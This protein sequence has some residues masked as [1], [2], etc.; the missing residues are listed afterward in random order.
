MR[1]GMQNYINRVPKEAQ[2]G[3]YLQ[4]KGQTLAQTSETQADN[5]VSS[6]QPRTDDL[7]GR[8]LKL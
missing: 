4:L 2:P 3:L 5:H 8:A 6:R 7:L 1:K